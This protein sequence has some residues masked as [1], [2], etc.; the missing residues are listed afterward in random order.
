[1]RYAIVLCVLLATAPATAGE[2]FRFGRG[3]IT[4]GDSTGTLIQK[5]GRPP[6]RGVQLENRLGAAIGERWEY[7]LRDKQVN[8]T[9]SGSK[10]VEIE[11]IR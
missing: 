3:V 9:I 5:A 4:T 10:I 1:M 8:F 11:E 2:T 6:D 7:Y